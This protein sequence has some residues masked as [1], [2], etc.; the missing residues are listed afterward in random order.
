MKVSARCYLTFFLSVWANLGLAELPFTQREILE[1]DA[2]YRQ[3][4]CFVKLEA[5]ITDRARTPDLNERSLRSAII[6]TRRREVPD[7]LLP[8]VNLVPFDWESAIEVRRGYFAYL[9]Y[10]TACERRFEAT[11]KIV[12][13]INRLIKGISFRFLHDAPAAESG[14]ADIDLPFWTDKPSYE[15]DIWPIM[16]GVW[17]GQPA[18]M[19]ALGE[20]MAAEKE[21]MGAFRMF[22]LAAERLPDGPDRSRATAGRDRAWAEIPPDRRDRAIAALDQNRKELPPHRP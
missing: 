17:K 2:R 21:Y 8:S 20:R 6:D 7:I 4:E 1:F 14:A 11:E 16:H 12:R 19:L 22:A 5:V 9:H 15:P 13:T 10:A 18:A 3:A